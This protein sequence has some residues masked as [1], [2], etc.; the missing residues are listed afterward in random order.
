MQTQINIEIRNEDN[1]IA[2]HSPYL[3]PNIAKF[4]A[5]GGKWDGSKFWIL[6]DCENSRNLLQE[7]FNWVEGCGVTEI[8]LDYYSR[9]VQS[10]GNCYFYKGYVLASRKHRDYAV[11]QPDG[12][13]LSKGSYP[14]SGGSVK[15][16]HPNVVNDSDGKVEYILTMFDG[17]KHETTDAEQAMKQIQEHIKN[18]KKKIIAAGLDD[19][20]RFSAALDYLSIALTHPSEF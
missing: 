6:P 20:R 1:T 13:I 3:Q 14:E 11:S 16:P 7:L 17:Q 4:K 10:Y 15:N 19:E 8:A 2:I 5:A 9:D 18:L 12:V